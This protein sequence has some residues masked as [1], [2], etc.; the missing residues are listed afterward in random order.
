MYQDEIIV[1]GLQY[2]RWDRAYF[3]SLKESGVTA[4]HVTLVYHETA[5]ETLSRFAEWNLH[6]ERNSDLIV[7]V[8][9]MDDVFSAKQRGKVG[10]FFGAQ[11][12]SPID[13]EIGL[14]EVM[15]KLGLLIMQLTYNNQSL[16]AT[17]CYEQEDSGVTRFGKQVIEEMNRVGM[18]IDMSHSAERSTLEAVD[19]SSRPICISHANPTVAHGALRNKSDEVIRALTGRGGLLGFSLYPFHLPNGSDCTLEAFC[20]MVADAASAYGAEHL[21][22]GSDLCQ[23]QPQRVLDWMRNGRWSKSLDFG[24]GS[25]SNAGWPAALPWFRDTRGLKNIYKG[26][27]DIGFSD[28]EVAGIL[29]RNWVRFLEAGLEPKK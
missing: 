14:V 8:M 11:N 25:A 13:D 2:S 1:D 9:T 21:A 15:R 16:L 17:G 4:V 23:N 28:E 18:I 20:Q 3:E 26:L 27:R 24:E 7:P 29:G 12:C 10:I 22:L 19:L 6:F 5:R